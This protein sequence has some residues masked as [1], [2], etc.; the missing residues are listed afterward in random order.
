MTA[1]VLNSLV[2]RLSPPP[3]PAV[4]AWGKSYS[5]G[6]GPLI[7][8]SQAVPGYPP[9][10]DMLRW[11]GEAASSLAYA[12]Y[13]PIEGES[14]LREAY[15]AHVSELYGANVTGGN[16]HIT[17]GCNQAFIC[18]VIAVA[19]AG[20]AVLMSDPFYFNHE[21][22]LS[23]LGI[24]TG[25]VACDSANGFVPTVEAVERALTPDVRALAL[26]TPNNP[27]GAI[28]PPAQLKAI[29]DVCRNNGIWLILDET[30][31]DFL[32]EGFGS[33]HGLLAEEGWQDN[34]IQLYSFSK[35]FCIPGHRLG[36]LT[37]GENVVEEIAKIMDNLQICAP[38]AAQ[39]AVARA[40]PA[41]AEWRA[42]NR[43][44]IE[45]R[46][47]ALS[48]VMTGLDGWK[49]EAIGAYFAFIRHPFEGRTSTDVAEQLAKRAGV[50]SIPGE[51]FGAEH[52]RFLRFA[53]ANAD[54]A[55]IRQLRGRMLDFHL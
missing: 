25:F 34:L 8:L 54:A 4:Q 43:L 44:E 48:E 16:I 17:S 37:A 53:F 22:T 36:A 23:M 38:R 7:D 51:Y 45:A 6:H 49:L 14:A 31:R 41:L 39:G 40:L 18:A 46:A 50:L 55:T 9:H 29:F 5:G 10:A 32:P 35:S 19:A 27:T 26:V 28:Y 3:I 21:T 11:L 47:K 1:A 24:K 13:G 42:G 12:N 33:P 20:D 15:A 30:Y 2:T 52:A